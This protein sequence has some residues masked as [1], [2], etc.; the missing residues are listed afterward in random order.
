[1][2]W[3][4]N[5]S[6][7]GGGANDDDD[8]LLRS[9]GVM[10]GDITMSGQSILA[11]GTL[12]TSNLSLGGVSV[13][14]SATEINKLSGVTAG[15][16]LASKCV[17]LDASKNVSS[18]GDLDC[19]KITS[20][21]ADIDEIASTNTLHGAVSMATNLSYQ[22]AVG[23]STKKIQF[24]KG[25]VTGSV[26]QYE[27]YADA[28]DRFVLS[29]TTGDVISTDGTDL[30]IS[31]PLSITENVDM[32]TKKITGL[33]PATGAGDAVEWNQLQ[34]VDSSAA[35]GINLAGTALTNAA[36]ALAA[37]GTKLPLIGGSLTGNLA[38]GG[39]DIS[40]I[41]QLSGT[42]NVTA[43]P[44]ITSVGTL[45]AFNVNS[46]SLPVGINSAGTLTLGSSASDGLGSLVIDAAHVNGS[47]DLMN[48]GVLKQRVTKD[49]TIFSDD[50]D[51]G[52]NDIKNVGDLDGL[53]TESNQSNVTKL[54]ELDGFKMKTGTVANI[55]TCTLSN[56][57]SLSANNIFGNVGTP[58]QPGITSLGTMTA[59]NADSVAAVN[60][61]SDDFVSI[62][63]AVGTN[64]WSYGNNNLYSTASNLG[65]VQIDA[66]DEAGSIQL[67]HNS[68]LKAS[69]GANGTTFS[70]GINC[71]M[72][73]VSSVGNP[74]SD[75][76]AANKK[77]IDNI[78]SA[79]VALNTASQSTADAALPKAGGVMSG[80]ISMGSSK[81]TNVT[82]GTLTGDA[83]NRSQ[84]DTVNTA[85][86]AAQTTATNAASVAATAAN[87]A[88][89][90]LPKAGGTMTGAIN[91]SNK[92]INM[93]A[94][95]VHVQDAV[96]MYQLNYV[97]GLGAVNLALATTAKTIANTA[98][99]NAATAQTRADLGVANALVAQ[100]TADSKLDA[101]GGTITGN[102]DVGDIECD[103][104]TVLGT[105]TIVNTSTSSVSDNML[106]IANTNTTDV[107]D[108]G[109]YGA[110]NNGF[111]GMVRDSTD[112]TYKVFE[113]A[114]TEPTGIVDTSETGFSLANFA[115]KDLTA[116]K[117]DLAGKIAG[118][119]A[120]TVGTDAVNKT[121]LDGVESQ[122]VTAQTT[123]NT[124]VT[125]AATALSVAGGK[126]SLGGGTLTGNLI[127]N[128]AGVAMG[129]QTITGLG[130]GSSAGDAVNKSQL[131]VVQ[132]ATDNTKAL[133][134]S[135][136][137]SIATHVTTLASHGTTLN[138]LTTG[139]S[140]NTTSINTH[141]NNINTLITD[142][143]TNATA[144][145]TTNSALSLLAVEV[146]NNDTTLTTNGT[147]ISTNATGVADNQNA[148]NTHTTQIA[149]LNT[150]MAA[151]ESATSTNASG[152]A[153]NLSTIGGHT[154]L[155]GTHTTAL[156]TLD[157]EM[158]AT[159][160]ATSTNATAITALN[161]TTG[162]H[163]TTLA[164][165]ATSLSTLDTEMAA[166]ESATSTNA[167][168][169]TALNTT[170]GSHTT[171]LASHTTALSTLDTEMTATEAAT[172]TNASDIT[173]L[174][175]TT[176]SH[177]TTLASH[178]TALSTLDTEMT[179]TENATSTNAT[180]ITALNTT[181]GSHTAS[182]TALNTATANNLSNI[183]SNDA[184]IVTLTN[185]VSS[186]LSTIGS[187]T[188]TLATLT[189]A[190]N[191]N[192]SNINSNDSD[193]AGLSTAVGANTTAI[194]SN[195]SDIATL[196]TGLAN[197][198]SSTTTNSSN[199]AT[200][201]STIGS[202]TSTLATLATAISAN[203]TAISS[204]DSDITGL[205]TA[206]GNNATAISS[207]DSDIA[208]LNTGVAS[209]VTL[210]GSHTSQLASNA[211][212][213]G[214]HTS[215]LSTNAT[216]I[217]LNLS[218]NTSNA[219]N[220]STNLSS[221]GSLNTG[222]ANNVTAISANGTAIASNL[223][224]IN[225][226]TTLIGT[227][228][229]TANTAVS[230]ALTADNKAVASQLSA[231]L[232]GVDGGVRIGDMIMSATDKS[233]DDR[234]L[235]ADASVYLQTAYPE[236]FT[237]IGLP[238]Y[239]PNTR[240]TAPTQPGGVPSG[241][242]TNGDGSILVVTTVAVPY[243]NLYKY[244]SVLDKYDNSV[245]TCS[246]AVGQA[247]SSVSISVDGVH[248][249]L[250]MTAAPFLRNY[251]LIGNVY[252]EI[253]M[254][255]LP[256]SSLR[257]SYSYDGSVMGVVMTATPFIKI[258][259]IVNHVYSNIA[260]PVS[261]AIGAGNDLAFSEDGST[262]V[263]VAATAP[264]A[265]HYEY[266]SGTNA[267][268]RQANFSV[269]PVGVC[270]E[271]SLT[272]NGD[273]LAISHAGAPYL[274]VW[275]KLGNSYTAIP[276]TGIP[277]AAGAGVS[278]DEEGNYLVYTHAAAPFNVIFRR[279]VDQFAVLENLLNPPSVAPSS[280]SFSQSAEF[281]SFTT[282]TAASPFLMSYRAVLPFNKTTHFAVPTC[283]VPCANNVR[284][285]IKAKD[286]NNN[287][288][289]D[290]ATNPAPLT[291]LSI[292]GGLDLNDLGRVSNS[293]DPVAEQDLVTKS[294]MDTAI[295]AGSNSFS[296]LTVAGDVNLSN[297][298]KVVNSIAPTVGGDLCN[299][300]Y[301]DAQIAA[302]SGG[303]SE[304]TY[305]TEKQIGQN[306]G[307]GVTLYPTWTNQ[308]VNV[309]GFTLAADNYTI[310]V[311]VAGVYQVNYTMKFSA[312]ST[313]WRLAEIKTNSDYYATGRQHG[314]SR[315]NAVPSYITDMVGSC[316]VRM[317]ANNSLYLYGVQTSGTNLTMGGGS[318][319][320]IM[321]L[322]IHRVGDLT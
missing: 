236:L 143:A 49:G 249:S 295:S 140:A 187:H 200:N 92:Q 223:A 32:N 66:R 127:F 72:N 210:L 296:S 190:V 271:V 2:D 136:A 218:N 201:L 141:T 30:T 244:D 101:S 25:P 37:A 255:S 316:L 38:L 314:S 73:I 281:L 125:N 164:S 158:A 41:G 80:S 277:I 309:G 69:I 317:N 207:N 13:S 205:S 6:S 274:S 7:G 206:I 55:N 186:N 217:A 84:L 139:V 286:V 103:N 176:G 58:A 227:A 284:E 300:T 189:T 116:V 174:N 102:L 261:N 114:T 87:S 113:S 21:T 191:N 128:G 199:I 233:L 8:S 47:V 167:S 4:Y 148:I 160:S 77:Y 152:I 159:E 251:Q 3:N 321:T 259:S 267:Y 253:S 52:T 112:K 126:L 36:A 293:L 76:D 209:N 75:F 301:V 122:T 269:N 204:N 172:S 48:N 222:V 224:S 29:S 145:T 173:A 1:M 294:Y 166:T 151:T 237:A 71:G 119:S 264:Y 54:G 146:G 50:I 9:G 273:F 115:C 165:H 230:N 252:T 24:T 78:N 289:A 11:A 193:I 238:S 179:A 149:T 18:L 276:M 154:T 33:N 86:I 291:S 278:F 157:T 85:T 245:Y 318:A 246:P 183:N 288:I 99:S 311:P 45:T 42:L 215:S 177:T 20:A 320:S 46:T 262:M 290:Y 285:Y 15:T 228:Q 35:S 129:G 65:S 242:A 263:V 322:S 272:R 153:S 213:L 60:I 89:Y 188:S 250:G 313:G 299:K 279:S 44:N 310:S 82:D 79:V 56:V 16:A 282:A 51:L 265:C 163:T 106:S 256:S 134:D 275:K 53:L 118:L 64:L 90:K 59:L 297:L 239:P 306:A 142:I 5:A 130:D 283:S 135:N 95:G 304:Y 247:A 123:A 298:G 97:Q 248:L 175:T 10:S 19:S 235:L 61:T 168:D 234:Y 111:T 231:D 31:K 96:N 302:N 216:A 211:T 57:G 68:V 169:I 132:V 138:T 182:I 197:T 270:S 232:A 254:S 43:Q 208:T 117:L 181:T 196:N 240:L 307:S 137:S 292:Q 104:L 147:N 257:S 110:Y 219:S 26:G 161:T 107:V 133:A 131:D 170:T 156:S 241:S 67:Q 229:T 28:S 308:Q 268:V 258:Y 100:T 221:I 178:T 39:N 202:H 34:A 105:S 121:Q 198:V 23:T 220:I 171:T 315:V 40:G 212:L 260:I 243:V 70:G 94:I 280:V 312:N 62:G 108:I 124:G 192:L 194:S 287:F 319:G 162:S 305:I 155:L 88:S 83:V 27:L 226:H 74:V 195:D 184:D 98:V 63:G 109:F 144:I 180:A 120:G 17:I 203:T 14:A 225:T 22:A 12:A 91:M 93:L 185:G 81:I 150:E 214:S 303:G 266:D